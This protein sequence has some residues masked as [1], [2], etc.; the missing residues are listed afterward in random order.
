M[1]IFC[2]GLSA[3]LAKTSARIV[4]FVVSLKSRSPNFCHRLFVEK[5]E[6]ISS[7]QPE[8]GHSLEFQKRH[9][10]SKAVQSL[11]TDAPLFTCGL[12]IP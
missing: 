12:F 3:K 5:E 11:D 1:Q 6:S 8:N 2:D 7:P 9:V 10:I 4:F